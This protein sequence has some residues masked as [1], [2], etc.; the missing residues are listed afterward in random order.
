[1]QTREFCDTFKVAYFHTLNFTLIPKNPETKSCTLLCDR[2]KHT[3]ALE[4]FY[5]NQKVNN[6][7]HSI[8]CGEAMPLCFQGTFVMSVLVFFRKRKER[9]HIV[10]TKIAIQN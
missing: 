5:V 1:M 3:A 9:E 6:Q 8:A 4:N 7:D 2:Q 10:S